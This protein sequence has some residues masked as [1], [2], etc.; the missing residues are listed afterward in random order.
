M[1]EQPYLL[2]EGPWIRIKD[3]NETALSLF[4]RHYTARQRRKIR[5]FIGPGEKMPLLTPDARALF[6]WRKFI[7]DCQ[8][9]QTGVNCA[10]FRN[11]GSS[12]GRSS[13]L[14]RAAIVEARERWPRERLYTYVDPRKTRHKRDPGRCFRRAGFRP[15]GITK[16]GLVILEIPAPH[17][18][19]TPGQETK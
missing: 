19:D 14:I 8:P 17:G 7:D 6:V 9:P 18:A 12:V 15:C 3:G 1:S 13:D 10:V 4:L 5:Q 16:S 11:E 2:A